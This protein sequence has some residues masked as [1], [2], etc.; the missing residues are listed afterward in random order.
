[1]IHNILKD[2]ST[3]LFIILAG[4][5]ISNAMVA[6]FMGVK[7]FSLEE[8]LGFKAV[9]IHLFG[10]S[11]S[12]NLTCGVLLWPV[13]FVMTDIINEY[14]GRKGV[15]FISWLAVIFIVYGF[16]MLF[17]AMNTTPNSWWI[18]SKQSAGIE[19]MSSAYNGIFG[20][21]LGIIIASMTAFLIGQLID[22][23]VFRS[24]KKRT[25]EK[26]IWLRATGSTLVSQFIDSFVV[27]IIAFYFYPKWV[28]NQG[29]AWPIN[30]VI[31]IG[32]VNYIY[33][34]IVAVLLTPV[35]Y[36]VHDRIEKYLGHD[37]SKKMKRA[38]MGQEDTL[39][40]IPIGG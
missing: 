4:F 5:L 26:H 9:N 28:P 25:G 6:E 37:L 17:A 39:S 10:D 1:M 15:K 23:F 16:V 34:F 24:I 2:K 33:K 36:L 19:N 21:G 22:V 32:I 11:Y 20:Q 8:T 30:Q 29:S 31:A 18:T 27:L 38:A 12:F 40:D 3:R 7:I 35:I 14:Y 13:V